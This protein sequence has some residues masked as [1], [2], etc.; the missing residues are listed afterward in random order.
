[1]PLPFHQYASIPVTEPASELHERLLANSADAV[2][3]AT[4]RGLERLAPL[5]R[6]RG[7]TPSAVPTVD[8]RLTGE[9]EIG[10]VE[11]TWSGDE[12]VTAWPSMVGRMLVV[13]DAAGG[14]RLVFLARRSPAM[15][16]ATIHLGR[17]H[18]RQVVNLAIQRF[19]H[20]LATGL[21]ATPARGPGGA[22]SFDRQPQFVHHLRQLDAD[23]QR[24]TEQLHADPDRL[25]RNATD[26]AIGRAQ[27]TLTAGRFRE[28]PAPTVET[29]PAR[30]G[31]L[32]TLHVAWQSDEDATGWPALTLTLVV[33]AHEAG[34][35][36]AVVSA[37]TPGYDMSQNRV[38]KH[39]RDQVLRNVGADL[40]D[41]ICD[42]LALAAADASQDPDL[43]DRTLAAA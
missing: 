30:P 1:M 16:L 3:S 31:E 38:D 15:E 22:T 4:A 36:L 40:A 23:P 19:L 7:L 18:R 5:V 26:V 8:T 27:D 35:E 29:R 20:E 34:T 21:G 12:E 11:V 25:A 43:A 10:A 24:L 33:E 6:S 37:R 28:P 41:A 13:P 2:A 9:D 17:L 14:S 42:D 32:G 39:Q